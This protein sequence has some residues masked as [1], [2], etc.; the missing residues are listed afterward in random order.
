MSWS[1]ASRAY[2][3][4]WP[5]WVPGSSASFGAAGSMSR[6]A[7]QKSESG[8]PPPAWSHTQAATTPPGL[9]TR[10]ISRKPAT[11]SDMK[12]TTS[13]AR[14]ASKES[15]AYGSASA[16]PCRTSIPGKRSWVAATNDGDGSM[17]ATAGAP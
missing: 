16:T 7:D 2:V 10:P 1:P 17:A 12:C 11:G 14:A 4:S 13:W 5:S 3:A 8:E 9:V 15:S 6:A